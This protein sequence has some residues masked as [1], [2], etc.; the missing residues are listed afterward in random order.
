[1]KRKYKLAQLSLG[2]LTLNLLFI[3]NV[4][5]AVGQVKKTLPSPTPTPIIE[6]LEIKTRP[7]PKYTN[8][9]HKNRIEGVVALE[10]T[11]LDSSKIG[12]VKVICGLPFGLT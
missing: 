3:A 9:A 4:S 5:Y 1:M 10:V 11:F 8:E 7:K 12:A 2:I 6:P